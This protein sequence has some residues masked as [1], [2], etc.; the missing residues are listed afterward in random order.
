MPAGEDIVLGIDPGLGTTGWGIIRAGAGQFKYVGSGKISTS[1]A[2]PMGQRLDKL[3][4]ELQD[5]AKSYDVTRCAVE[6]GFVGKSHIS[7][8]KLGQARA[9]AILAAQV[10]Q[11][12]V[13]EVTPRE[14]KMAITGIGSAAKGQVGFMVSRILGL[15]FD[16][17]EEDISDALAVALCHAMRAQSALRAAAR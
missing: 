16:R 13:L 9:A 15:E 4:R 1:P 7:A 10:L 6:S 3:F 5:I 8:L 2:E 12:P 11:I 14:V 17:G